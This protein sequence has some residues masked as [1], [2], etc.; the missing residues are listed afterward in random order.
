MHSFSIS[1][2][3]SWSVEW[4]AWSPGRAPDTGG[5]RAA[6]TGR[7]KSPRETALRARW[8]CRLE[9]IGQSYESASKHINLIH[10]GTRSWRWNPA[11]SAVLKQIRR[12]S[13][14]AAAPSVWSAIKTDLFFT[15]K[16]QAKIAIDLRLILS[17]KRSWSGEGQ[18]A[19]KLQMLRELYVQQGLSWDLSRGIWN[20]GHFQDSSEFS[21]QRRFYTNTKSV[22]KSLQ[23]PIDANENPENTFML[24]QVKSIKWY[25]AHKRFHF[26]QKKSIKSFTGNF[27]GAASNE[28]LFFLQYPSVQ[29]CTSGSRSVALWGQYW[30]I[31]S[32]T[33]AQN[34]STY[35]LRLWF[36]FKTQ[37]PAG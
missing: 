2:L 13:L 36:H 6:A 37:C 27:Q 15:P 28:Q 21:V 31:R 17:R 4:S 24:N 29:M 35:P 16:Q 18:R 34:P 8:A 25:F 30:D 22:N 12:P 3:F 19:D 1:L 7:H 5:G 11:A 14:M 20:T 26:D 10:G 32:V 9:E 33:M 23:G